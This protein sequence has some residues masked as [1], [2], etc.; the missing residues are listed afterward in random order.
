MWLLNV[1]L[2]IITIIVKHFSS[3]QLNGC[4]RCSIILYLKERREEKI[5]KKKYFPF[6]YYIFFC[7]LFVIAALIEVMY[8]IINF[9]TPYIAYKSGL[10]TSSEMN[11]KS[12]INTL[13][14][15]VSFFFTILLCITHF[16]IK[17]C[18]CVGVSL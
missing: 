2:I 5:K 4:H 3:F 18:V 12:L 1:T 15:S 11:N 7:V 8:H 6:Y 10:G 14:L 13:S 17:T 9:L 16:F